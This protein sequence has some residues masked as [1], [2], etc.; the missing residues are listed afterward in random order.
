MP[1]GVVDGTGGLMW[2]RACT[3]SVV[4]SRKKKKSIKI[5]RK[6]KQ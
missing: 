6:K 4:W 1:E 2:S 5:R 3:I